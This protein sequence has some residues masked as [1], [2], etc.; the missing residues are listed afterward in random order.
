M[1]KKG[2][3]KGK[4][5]KGEEKKAKKKNWLSEKDTVSYEQQITDNNKQLAR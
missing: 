2:K 3:G 4:G 5:K 1:P